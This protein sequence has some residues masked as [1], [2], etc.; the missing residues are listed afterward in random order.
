[1]KI[2][3]ILKFLTS[4]LGVSICRKDFVLFFNNLNNKKLTSI[5]L[6]FTP[7][8]L[9]TNSNQI[10]LNIELEKFTPDT[11]LLKTDAYNT[12]IIGV[13]NSPNNKSDLIYREDVTK[14]IYTQIYS[15]KL[16]AFKTTN[17]GRIYW[18]T[19]LLTRIHEEVPTLI[20][21]NI[22]EIGAGS[23]VGSA[24]VSKFQ[25]VD[26]VTAMDY[27]EYTVKNLMPR[28]F[29]STDA[30]SSKLTRACGDYNNLKF[31]DH[32]FDTVIALGSLHHSIDIFKTL[33]ECFRV[34]RPGANMIIS[35]Y[36]FASDMKQEEYLSWLE[37]PVEEP[38]GTSEQNNI[39]KNKDINEHGR[40][41]F[42]YQAAA[43]KAGFNLNTILF[44]ANDPEESRFSLIQRRLES[45]KLFKKPTSKRLL[46]YDSNENVMTFNMQNH[47]YYPI[48]AKNK[49]S[50]LSTCLFGKKYG[51]PQYD[52]LLLILQKPKQPFVGSIIKYKSGQKYQVDLTQIQY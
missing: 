22:L 27:E 46:G 2:K 28:V 42:I 1:M 23:A 30:I 16:R 34:L 47:I 48:F 26:T 45:K 18:R 19:N 35:D 31:P 21:G 14:D 6:I 33:D 4:R 32:T 52:N 5:P 8:C 43:F 7:Y 44:D 13:E 12:P 9:I 51:K 40:P 36:A 37:K 3:N 50:I 41:L 10:L 17:S 25:N 38:H 11:E 24:A 29:W 49:P 15:N 20:S 39:L